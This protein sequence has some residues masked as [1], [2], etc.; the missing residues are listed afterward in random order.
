MSSPRHAADK[1]AE[2]SEVPRL[3]LSKIIAHHQRSHQ[4]DDGRV[5][6]FYADIDSMIKGQR[7]VKDRSIVNVDEEAAVY[8]K[9]LYS[10]A[11]AFLSGFK[12]TLP[13]PFKDLLVEWI[14][15][16][17]E[18]LANKYFQY[19]YA[20][21]LGGV[22]VDAQF[23]QFQDA[24]TK[25]DA[26]KQ[27]IIKSQAEGETFLKNQKQA[28]QQYYL[29]EKIPVKF[30][31]AI[32]NC[33]LDC[34][35]SDYGKAGIIPL[36]PKI[37]EKMDKHNQVL[38]DISS[39]FSEF[40]SECQRYEN[41]LLEE[42]GMT[43]DSLSPEMLQIMLNYERAY[44]DF[45]VTKHQFDDLPMDHVERNL[46][47]AKF[48]LEKMKPVSPAIEID[49]V[50]TPESKSPP[51]V[52]FRFTDSPVIKDSL[53]APDS[54]PPPIEIKSESASL[55]SSVFRPRPPSVPRFKSP[56]HPLTITLESNLRANALHKPVPKPREK[57]NIA[58]PLASRARVTK[59]I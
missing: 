26:I 37:D 20:L 39:I 23:T 13:L 45:L 31:V 44:R 27:R 2:A 50:S 51:T 12:E 35:R 19:R 30:E 25:Y 29:G 48:N 16:I 41:S 15:P 22:D 33:Y 36:D 49:A 57:E 8:E 17:L 7:Q 55:K 18:D 47:L 10:A 43:R 34:L 21:K 59:K 6:P 56:K 40:C 1:K 9:N 11:N 4:T 14:D 38:S 32:D 46:A 54:P 3:D 53:T 58:R 42:W 28:I 24:E 52:D 5:N